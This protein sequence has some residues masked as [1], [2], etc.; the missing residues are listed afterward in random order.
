ME[1]GYILKECDIACLVVQFDMSVTFS[2][3]PAHS[4][5]VDLNLVLNPNC[6][7][8][9]TRFWWWIVF[10]WTLLMR[11]KSMIE[12]ICSWTWTLML[13]FQLYGF[14]RL[15]CS[16]RLP[17]WIH[18]LWI[19]LPEFELC[20]WI[21]SKGFWLLHYLLLKCMNR[22]EVWSIPPGRSTSSCTRPGYGSN[23]SLAAR[24]HLSLSLTGSLYS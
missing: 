8:M 6:D 14:M 20:K 2:L 19:P 4:I 7:F 13:R 3:V 12:V 15:A 24:R 23:V 11:S 22:S 10:F 21:C 17:D 5:N 9:F 1:C 18:A 16:P